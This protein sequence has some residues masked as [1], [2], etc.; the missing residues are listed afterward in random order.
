M[1]SSKYGGCTLI[2]LKRL[3]PCTALGRE[4]YRV[5]TLAFEY[6]EHS[7]MVGQCLRHR[8][9]GVWLDERQIT[10]QDEPPC[11]ITRSAHC[12][13]NGVAHAG[14]WSGFDVERQATGTHR[15]HRVL[16]HGFAMQQGLQLGACAAR[17][18][19]ALPPAAGQDQDGGRVVARQ[20]P[21]SATGCP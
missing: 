18:D 17:C 21:V 15:V 10:G 20:A 16:Q 7:R 5:A 11:R 6:G 8:A 3:Q 4:P 14:V 1:V 13:S 2:S 12:R 9:Q 19:K